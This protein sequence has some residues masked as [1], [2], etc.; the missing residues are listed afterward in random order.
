MTASSELRAAATELRRRVAAALEEMRADPSWK[1][2]P[3][4]F[5]AAIGHALATALDLT[6]DFFDTLDPH[7][8]ADHQHDESAVSYHLLLIARQING[9]GS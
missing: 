8:D 6:A 4:P 3:T 9:G 7:L 1:G 2:D 5:T